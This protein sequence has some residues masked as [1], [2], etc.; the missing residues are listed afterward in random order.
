MAWLLL[1]LVGL[2]ALGKPTSG[3]VPPSTAWTVCLLMLPN[4][5]AVVALYWRHRQ[6]VRVFSENT[7]VRLAC[8]TLFLL[9]SGWQHWERGSQK[10]DPIRKTL[11]CFTVLCGLLMLAWLL[12]E[13][14]KR[15]RAALRT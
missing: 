7:L 15:I 12:V 3:E 5:L 6:R 4:A 11:A 14:A 1:W 13:V 2:M 8:G 9:H 10:G